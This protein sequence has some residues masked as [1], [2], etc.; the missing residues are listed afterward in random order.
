MCTI[1]YISIDNYAY[2]ANYR[3][4]S[5][6]NGFDE[7][8]GVKVISTFDWAGPQ[9][10]VGRANTML[11]KLQVQSPKSE[12]NGLYVQWPWKHE[13]SYRHKIQYVLYM[14]VILSY[15]IYNV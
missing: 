3:L 8:V 7:N 11:Y 6:G 13:K 9:F 15:N 10:W 12:T 2:Y 5:Q 4:R 14:S 1:C